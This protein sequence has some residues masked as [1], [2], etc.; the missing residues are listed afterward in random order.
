MKN[1]DP[2]D[3]DSFPDCL[4]LLR[5][6]AVG[7]ARERSRRGGSAVRHSH[8]W[9]A[10]SLVARFQSVISSCIGRPAM[11]NDLRDRFD[12]S[13]P[14]SEGGGDYRPGQ[15]R[16]A[17]AGALAATLKATRFPL[18]RGGQERSTA[19]LSE[20]ISQN[21]GDAGPVNETNVIRKL[22]CRLSMKSNIG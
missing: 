20:I 1:P 9:H 12:D 14:Q 21:L 15:W 17:L 13:K 5:S 11:M 6:W 10:S 8:H 19:S 16:G 18:L 3:K 22:F 7:Y 4:I 2:K